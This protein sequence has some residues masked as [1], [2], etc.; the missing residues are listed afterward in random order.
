MNTKS[1]FFVAI[2]V[3]SQTLIFTNFNVVGEDDSLDFKRQNSCETTFTYY[4]QTSLSS[5]EVVGEWEGWI[6]NNLTNLNGNYSIDLN[7]DE[8]FYCYKLIIDEINWVLDPSNGYRKYCD[9]ILNS[10]IIVGN[11]S[12]PILSIASESEELLNLKLN[13]SAGIDGSEI[14]QLDIYLMNN[15]KRQNISYIWNEEDWSVDINVNFPLNSFEYGKYTLNVQAFDSEGRGSNQISYPF[16]FEESSFDWNGALVY[17]IMTD[18]FVNGNISND[19]SS[20]P[21]VSPGA[22]WVGGDFAGVISML[23]LIHI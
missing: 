4:S 14:S 21:D 23:S 17:M 1:I 2:L 11:F 22:D 19:P 8:G 20:I 13:Y 15:F 12:Y 6:R 9:G 5:V 7:I 18:R 3:L 16:W 10:G